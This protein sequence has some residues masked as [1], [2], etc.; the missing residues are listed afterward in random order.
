MRLLQLRERALQL[1][2]R[3]RRPEFDDERELYW[4]A[5]DV[6]VDDALERP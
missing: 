4:V 6:E 5:T 3:D 1:L 2:Y